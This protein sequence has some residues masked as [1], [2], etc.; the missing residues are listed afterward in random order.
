MSISGIEQTDDMIAILRA[1]ESSGPEMA[2]AGT[3]A[4]FAAVQRDVAAGKDPN[5]GAPFA[6]TKNGGKPL[7]N[8]AKALSWRIVG[9]IGFL[10]LTGHYI[11]HFFGT[12]Y[13]PERKANLQGRLPARYGTAIAQGMVPVFRAVTKRGKIGTK[14]YDAWKAKRA[15]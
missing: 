9:T 12:G 7:K 11:F 5:T 14:A 13:L 1:V 2:A 10:V 3:Q 8:A 4:L 6:A 15:A